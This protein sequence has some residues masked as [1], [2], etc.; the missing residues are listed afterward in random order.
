MGT[1]FPLY[2]KFT[3]SLQKQ[4]A[5][6]SRQNPEGKD[7]RENT[8]A[9]KCE[10]RRRAWPAT[11]T[12]GKS[13]EHRAGSK[14]V[15]KKGEEDRRQNEKQVTSDKLLDNCLKVKEDGIMEC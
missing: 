3:R 2:S 13:R 6:Y 12:A 11:H 9:R 1:L 5:A 15:R 4:K 10:K 14:E 7:H 8:N